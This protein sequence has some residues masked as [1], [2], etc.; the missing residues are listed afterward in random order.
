[1]SVP[2]YSFHS[3]TLKLSNKRIDFPIP[4][5]KLPNKRN[6]EYS[7]I[8]LFILFHSIPF[9]LPKRGLMVYFKKDVQDVDLTSPIYCNL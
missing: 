7:K 6:E 3:L 4:P 9:S 8:I 1:M 2:S 5:L